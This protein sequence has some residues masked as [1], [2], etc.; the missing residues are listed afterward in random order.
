MDIQD[1]VEQDD[2]TRSIPH[3]KILSEN[4]MASGVRYIKIELLIAMAVE[5]VKKHTIAIG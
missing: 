1:S 2:I 5:V 3:C 4:K